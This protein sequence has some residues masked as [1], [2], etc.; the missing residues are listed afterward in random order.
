MGSSFKIEISLY[1]TELFKRGQDV[2]KNKNVNDKAMLVTPSWSIV[3]FKARYSIK[4]TLDIANAVITRNY[5]MLILLAID[6]RLCRD[7]QSFNRPIIE[8]YEDYNENDLPRLT[9]SIHTVY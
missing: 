3:N 6:P 1:V 5:V 7:L 8:Q 9:R 2:F 4:Q